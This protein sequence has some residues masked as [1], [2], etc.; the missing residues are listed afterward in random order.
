[1]RYPAVAGQFYS[2]DEDSLLHEIEGCYKSP[3]GPGR[4]PSLK[5]GR[6][7]IKGLV[8]PHAGYMFSGPVAS[9]SYLALAE[10]GFPDS[11][12]VIGPN[13]T[14]Y[15]SRVALT[16]QDFSTPLGVVK[17][18]TELARELIG[19]VIEDDI[20][21]HRYEHSIE[22][23]LPFLQHIKKEIKFLPIC[24]ASQ[25]YKTAREVGQIISKAISGR[26]VV[27]IASTD[28]SHYEPKEVAIR[29]DRLAIDAILNRDAKA[30]YS[31]VLKNG[32]TMCGYGPVM[33]MLE[34]VQGKE[35][36]LLKYS[37]SGDVRPMR[38]VVGY[39]A[40]AVKQ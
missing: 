8:C 11:F 15:G 22:V 12:I 35:A 2:G 27:V 23:Q 38:D 21:A 33:A 9:H 20:T 39:G 37:T 30:L 3:I 16:T 10:D 40:I 31:T 13:H 25:E 36:E 7:R 24:M 6:R 14:G 5:K 29:K 18:D 17:A 34:A 28:F 19:E 26:D 1:V 32:I 4:L